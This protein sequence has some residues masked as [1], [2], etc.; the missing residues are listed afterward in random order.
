MIKVCLLVK[1]ITPFEKCKSTFTHLNRVWMRIHYF[2]PILRYNIDVVRKSKLLLFV[3]EKYSVYHELWRQKMFRNI[4][5]YITNFS[6][7]TILLL[8]IRINSFE[9][10][11]YHIYIPYLKS[12][13]RL[14]HIFYIAKMKYR[15]FFPLFV[16]PTRWYTRSDVRLTGSGN[17]TSIQVKMY[18]LR[19][20]KVS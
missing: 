14:L 20:F 1:I 17:T 11:I 2:G 15:V 6:N 7:L 5:T 13:S 19:N 16:T 9:L 18:R 3:Y 12:I 10:Y 8:Y 4:L